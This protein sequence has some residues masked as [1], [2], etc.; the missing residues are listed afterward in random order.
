MGESRRVERSE[1][2]AEFPKNRDDSFRRG[3]LLSQKLAQGYG[4]VRTAQEKEAGLRIDLDPAR[5]LP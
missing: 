2:F 1:P 3:L 5:I 4:G